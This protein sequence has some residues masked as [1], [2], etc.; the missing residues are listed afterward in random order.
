MLTRRK[1]GAMLG[2]SLVFLERARA[3]SEAPPLT[4]FAAASLKEA[5]DALN[6]AWAALGNAP[7]RLVLAASGV[8]ARQ[9]EQ[10]A[11]A[12][13]F[14]SAD[15]VWM[16]WAQTRN[17]IRP[18]TRR[19]LAGNRLVVIAPS[20]SARRLTI[21][22]GIDAAAFHANGKLAIGDPKAVPAGAYAKAA[23][24]RL[25][26]WDRLQARLV[27]VE[28]VRMAL[29]LVA[30]GEAETGIVYAS[31]A[32][33]EPKVAVIGTIPSEYHPPIR[34]PAALVSTSKH[35]QAPAFL[36]F[37]ASPPAQA[38]LSRFGFTAGR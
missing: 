32:L 30:R 8:L 4:V 13:L 34:Y 37:L 25:D 35:P 1:L 24:E 3:Q 10:G 7:A 27:M 28:N 29:V 26:L 2:A 15:D 33:A 38:I 17:L 19:L 5:L 31:D 21:A 11:P 18:E 12:D 36:A 22:P 9:V 23:L 6:A 16:D 20:P 14:L